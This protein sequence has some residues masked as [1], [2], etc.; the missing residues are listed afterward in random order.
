M[1]KLTAE[2]AHAR[3]LSHVAAGRF[4]EAEKLLS[5]SVL[6]APQVPEYRATLAEV[7]RL[8][9]ESAAAAAGPMVEIE[10]GE[11]DEDEDDEWMEADT[12]RLASEVTDETG[13]DLDDVIDGALDDVIDDVIDDAL[14]DVIDGALDDVNDGPAE[15]AEPAPRSVPDKRDGDGVVSASE[16]ATEAQPVPSAGAAARKRETVLG[17]VTADIELGALLSRRELAQAEEQLRAHLDSAPSESVPH[18]MLAMVLRARG[19]RLAEARFHADR[20]VSL[21]PTDLEAHVLRVRL[22]EENRNSDSTQIVKQAAIDAASGDH[23][24]LRS[25]GRRLNKRIPSAD[26]AKAAAKAKTKKSTGRGGFPISGRAALLLAGLLLSGGM[27]LYRYFDTRDRPVDVAVFDED[28]G[29]VE[30]VRLHTGS[31]LKVTI[32]AERWDSWSPGGSAQAL[33]RIWADASELPGIEVAF[34]Y[35]ETEELLGTVRENQ[36]YVR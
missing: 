23:A 14:D 26:Q 30:A 21:D 18:R 16:G 19:E 7:R 31:E 13:D 34:V 28:L 17:D 25:A 5:I 8:A 29:V 22:A 1:P 10:D 24:R 9:A 32:P 3:A 11:G 12:T 20:A 4:E 6:R 36:V 15:P 35:S 2:Q 27:V 33:L